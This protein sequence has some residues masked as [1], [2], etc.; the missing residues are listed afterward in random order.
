MTVSAAVTPL[1][2]KVTVN[3]AV[4]A[5]AKLAMEQLIGVVP[6]TAGVTQVQPTGTVPMD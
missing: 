2:C 4:P 3:V 6:P 5:F 1:T